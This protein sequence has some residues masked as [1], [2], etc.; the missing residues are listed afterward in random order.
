MPLTR[1]WRCAAYIKSTIL[2]I[3]VFT[4]RFQI[5]AFALPAGAARLRLSGSGRDTQLLLT[6]WHSVTLCQVARILTPCWCQTG[7]DGW[8][9][10]MEVQGGRKRRRV[11]DLYVLC[12]KYTTLSVQNQVMQNHFS[13]ASHSLGS[14]CAHSLGFFWSIQSLP[15]SLSSPLGSHRPCKGSEEG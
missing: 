13:S 6:K 9:Q 15:P 1:F 12:K 8:M 5:N 3:I 2:C 10:E 4:V 7:M 14:I 11:R